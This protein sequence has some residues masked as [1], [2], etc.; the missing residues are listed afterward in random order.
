MQ[1][2]RRKT[3][4]GS[5]ASVKNRDIL[6]REP[7][8]VCRSRVQVHKDAAQH[9]LTLRGPEEKSSG[10]FSWPQA[11]QTRGS[12]RRY[13]LENRAPEQEKDVRCSDAVIA[14]GRGPS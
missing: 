7:A 11:M 12:G 1:A 6:L 10:S 5:G 2:I 3:T 14:S 13:V 4:T 8:I 9:Q